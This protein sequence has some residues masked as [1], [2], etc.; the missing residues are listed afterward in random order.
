MDMFLDR[1]YEAVSLDALIAQVGGSRRNIYHYFGG[2]EGLFIAVVTRLCE[3]L[4]RPLAELE[5]EHQALRPALT[6]FGRQVLQLGLQPRVLALHRLMIGEGQRFSELAQAIWRAGHDNATRI[7]AA[8]I[9]GRQ[10]SELRDD[11]SAYELAAQFISL[12][13]SDVQL[14]ALVGLLPPPPTRAQI[15]RILAAAV[16]MFLNGAMRT[17]EATVKPQP[18]QVKRRSQR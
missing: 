2:K 1:G 16:E 10:G 6:E 11:I 15:S 8:W 4:S 7:L 13:L 12:V 3:E 9:E 5:I 18:R 17:G 14:R